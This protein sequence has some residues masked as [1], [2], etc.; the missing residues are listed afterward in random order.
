ME[1]HVVLGLFIQEQ[2]KVAPLLKQIFFFTDAIFSDKYI[3]EF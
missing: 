1:I 2:K 3:Q